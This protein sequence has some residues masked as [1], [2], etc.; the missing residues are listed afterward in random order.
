METI[1]RGRG[2]LEQRLP[3][4]GLRVGERDREAVPILFLV[5]LSKVLICVP[6]LTYLIPLMICQ[7]NTTKGNFQL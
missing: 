3:C 6:V 7:I 1:D 5:P 4:C 2:Q